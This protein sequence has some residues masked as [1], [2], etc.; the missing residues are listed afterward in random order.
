[1]KLNNGP[2][3]CPYCGCLSAYFEIDRI[4][5]IREKASEEGA[6]PGWAALLTLHKKKAFCL[7]C[8]KT[9]E[10]PEEKQQQEGGAAPRVTTSAAPVPALMKQAVQ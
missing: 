3:L 4:A 1:M 5:A 6:W 7:M 10:Q 8:H 2:I 9:I